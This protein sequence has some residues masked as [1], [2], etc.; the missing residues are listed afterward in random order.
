[1]EEFEVQATCSSPTLTSQQQGF[2]LILDCV[3]NPSRTSSNPAFY[4]PCCRV[5]NRRGFSKDSKVGMDSSGL[6]TKFVYHPVRHRISQIFEPG[7]K[8]LT[9]D[10]AWTQF[11]EW[12]ERNQIDH[13][14]TKP[15]TIN[16][17]LCLKKDHNNSPL[18]EDEKVDEALVFEA[19]VRPTLTDSPLSIEL[20]E[21]NRELNCYKWSNKDLKARIRR[22]MIRNKRIKIAFNKQLQIRDEVI[23][24]LLTALNNV[25][26]KHEG[27]SINEWK[28]KER[29]YKG[30]IDFTEGDNGLENSEGLSSDS[31]DGAEAAHD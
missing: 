8:P 14:F 16:Q 23:K 31:E 5:W 2:K 22:M 20:K 29:I 9:F 3:I 10:E 11:N 13:D 21:K 24:D 30:L 17:R 18:R 26:K 1:M 19:I 15:F 27:K 6:I 28:F 4:H 7:S 12:V 25:T